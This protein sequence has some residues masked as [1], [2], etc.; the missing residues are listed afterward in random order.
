MCWIGERFLGDPPEEPDKYEWL[1]VI[2][3][4]RIDR[5]RFVSVMTLDAGVLV[6]LV[7]YYTGILLNIPLTYLVVDTLI[8]IWWWRKA[9]KRKKWIEE[10]RD[11][12]RTEIILQKIQE[13]KD[14]EERNKNQP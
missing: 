3:G 1:Y 7:Q 5:L 12:D 11:I 2:S 10:E 6:V 13:L 14:M 8:G 9:L 4:R